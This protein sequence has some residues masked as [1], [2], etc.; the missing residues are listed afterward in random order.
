[1]NIETFLKYPATF[2]VAFLTVYLLVP[3][4]AAFAI[5]IGAVDLPGPR[6]L[7]ARPI[8]RVGGIAVFFGFHLA[9]ALR[10][11]FP[12]GGHHLTG[13]LT[14]TWW[15]SYLCIS[16]FMLTVG[17]TDDVRGLK[18]VTKLLYQIAGASL[19]FLLDVRVG[20]ILGLNLPVLFDYGVTVFWFLAI[21]NAF[22]LIDG[23]DGLAAGLASIAAAGIMGSFLFRGLPG[24]A[25]VMVALFGA[26][27]A[28][29]RYNFNPASIFLGDGGSMFLGFTLASV[30]LST[31]SKG[32]VM[33][34][35]GVPLL[36]VGVPIFD[37]MLAVWRRSIR[38]AFPNA[39]GHLNEKGVM[40]FDMEH[41]HHRLIRAGLNQRRVALMLYM[42][43]ASLVAVGLLSLLFSDQATGIF[44]MAFVVGTYVAVRHVAHV[45]LWDSGAAI[46]EGFRKPVSGVLAVLMY[47]LVDFFLLVFSLALSVGVC[48]FSFGVHTADETLA[49]WFYSIPVWC[50]IPFIVLFAA[51]TY[52]RVWS[53]ARI[54]EYLI[55]GFSI[56]GG[57]LLS[58]STAMLL[59][60]SSE[61]LFPAESLMYCSLAIAMLAGVRSLP[62]L[63]T[64]LM[65]LAGRSPSGAEQDRR[66]LIVYG[67]GER[68]LLY[69]RNRD[70][71]VMERHGR[72]PRII[73][74]IDDDRNLRR[75]LVFGYRVLGG[76]RDLAR[77]VDAGQ[78][79]EIILTAPLPPKR[80]NRLI[81]LARR[82]RVAVTEW[83]PASRSLVAPPVPAPLAV[84]TVSPVLASELD[85]LAATA[86]SVVE[87]TSPV[88]QPPGFQHAANG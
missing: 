60:G 56:V 16:A 23:M 13:C 78:V 85:A 73:G 27:L 21:T 22:N 88:D 38:K 44:I 82:S 30:A 81:K 10:F 62:R 86:T 79:E 15:L 45:E 59:H 41:L 71:L 2:A 25:L 20:N 35:M 46:L 87:L 36:A 57:A 72:G 1:M 11:L 67:V 5:K 37:T 70:Q 33:A 69:L 12:M 18:P 40:H 43:N 4:V 8:P 61:H 63:V 84:P 55:L 26:C 77:I 75:R 32:T 39:T 29:L 74:L 19:M 68:G 66:S 76:M 17:V 49:A 9:C 34:S 14:T 50:G 64:D 53:K 3:R 47:P 52:S 80:L 83:R 6:R 42:A 31:G 58:W 65:L 54:S 7:H 28:F 24:D 51:R 48:R